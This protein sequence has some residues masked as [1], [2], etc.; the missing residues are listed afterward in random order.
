[1]KIELIRGT[2]IAGV[3]K[4]PGD[5]IEVDEVLAS[6]LIATGKGI[7]HAEKPKKEDRSV[8]LETSSAPK[9]K[10]RKIFK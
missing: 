6:T 7:P 8:N 10:T 2:V 3:G 4:V 1:M 5:V 9:T